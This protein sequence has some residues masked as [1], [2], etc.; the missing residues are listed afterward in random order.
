ALAYIEWISFPFQPVDNLVFHSFP[1]SLKALL[2]SE[3][4]ACGV[5]KF[6]TVNYL[7][8]FMLRFPLEFP[9]F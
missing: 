1:Q 9:T 6:S 2:T 7:W 8:A 5:E 3:L 4:S